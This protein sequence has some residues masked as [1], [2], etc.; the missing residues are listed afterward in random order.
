MTVQTNY[1]TTLKIS[2]DYMNRL[3]ELIERVRD[4]QLEIGD[5]L[6]ELIELYE[7]REGVLKY[8]SGTLNYSYELLQ[9]YENAARRWTAEKRLEYPLMDWSFYRNADPNDPRDIE[10]LNQ[11]IDE[12]WNVTTFKEHKYPAIVQPYAMVG[13]ALGVLQKVELQ[14]ARLRGSL[15]NICTRLENLKRWIREFEKPPN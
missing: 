13:K 8:I 15:E 2:D 4:S 9:E 1:K 12:G 11:A 5:I 3:Q 6:I 14:D 7:D 10:L